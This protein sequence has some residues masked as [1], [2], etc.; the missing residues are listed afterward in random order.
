MAG[1]DILLKL[2]LDD[3]LVIAGIS[4]IKRQIN[5]LTVAMKSDFQR[6]SNAGDWM[7]AYKTKAENLNKQIQLQRKLIADT[8]KSMRGLASQGKANTNEHDKLAVKLTKENAELQK[9]EKSLRATELGYQRAKL[10]IQELAHSED[11]MARHTKSS[12]EALE[13]QGKKAQAARV[14]LNGLMGQHEKLGALVKAEKSYLNALAHEI[15]KDNSEYKKLKAQLQETTAKF[16]ADSAQARKEKAALDELAHSISRNTTEYKEQEIAISQATA[17]HAEAAARIKAIQKQYG[18][19]TEGMAKAYDTFHTGGQKV[20]AAG[21][22]IRNAGYSMIGTTLAVGGAFVKGAQD[23]AELGH[24]YNI[25]GTLI[26]TDAES[27]MNTVKKGSAEWTHAHN[28][29]INATKNVA[30]MQ[31][32]GRNVSLKYGVS[33][34]EVASGYEELVRKGYGAESS[35]KSV[36]AMAEAAMASGDSFGSTL[37][38]V[39]STLESFGLNTEVSA[40]RLHKF[41]MKSN[42]MADKTRAVAN[43]LAYAADITATDFPKL[44]LAM[45]Y[46][47]NASSQL[48]YTIAD[49]ASVLGVLSNNGLEASKAGTGLRQVL[50]SLAA[51]SS[52]AK[53]ILDQLGISLTQFN[54][55]SG[56]Q[57]MRTLP[58][59]FGQLNAKL[60][61]LNPDEKTGILKKIFG[62]TGIAAAGIM[63]DQFEQMGLT[64]DKVNASTK[65]LGKGQ[66]YISKVAKRNMQDAQGQVKIL[67]ATWDDLA[68]SFAR[69]VLPTVI[70]FAKKAKGVVEWFGKLPK[71]LQSSISHLVLMSAT[72]A[73]ILIMT[74]NLVRLFGGGLLGI[75]QMVV[76]ISKLR[77]RVAE[78][79][80][81]S[82]GLSTGKALAKIAGNA[83]KA[84]L[85]VEVA[86]NAMKGA[87]VAAGAGEAAST[88]L[89]AALGGISLATV[90]VVAGVAAVGVGTALLVTHFNKTQA[91]ARK[92][93]KSINQYGINV[94]NYSSKVKES[95]DGIGQASANARVALD[96]LTQGTDIPTEKYDQLKQAIEDLTE[97]VESTAKEKIQQYND[98]LEDPNV[99][100]TIKDDIRRRKGLWEQ[101]QSFL[102][103]HKNKILDIQKRAQAENRALTAEEKA[104]ILKTQREI[105]GVYVDNMNE[106]SKKDKELVKDMLDPSKW[107][108]LAKQNVD[109]LQLMNKYYAKGVANLLKKDIETVE[110]EIKEGGVKAELAWADFFNKNKDALEPIVKNTEAQV[111]KMHDAFNDTG[112]FDA[113]QYREFSNGLKETLKQAGIDYE[114][115]CKFNKIATQEQVDGAQ[116]AFITGS[117]NTTA[118]LKALGLKS[119]KANKQMLNTLKSMKEFNELP[120]DMKA[121]LVHDE[122]TPKITK[123]IEKAG[124]WDNI[125][126]K[127]KEIIANDL[128]SG[129]FDKA[130]QEI[131]E[132]NQAIVDIK[133]IRAQDEATDEFFKAM[134]S[135]QAW[136]DLPPQEKLA[137]AH[138]QAT[139]DFWQAIQTNT[140]WNN[141]P[142]NVKNAIANDIASGKINQAKATLNSWNGHPNKEKNIKAKNATHAGVSAAIGMLNS[143]PLVK[144]VTI[145]AKVLTG[146]F[147]AVRG[148]L[149]FKT[150][151]TTTDEQPVWLGDGRKHEVYMTPQ[152]DFGVTPA[153]DTLYMLPKGSKIFPSISQFMSETGLMIDPRMIPKHATG[154]NVGSFAATD[155]MEQIINQSNKLNNGNVNVTVDT[156]KLEI[157]L[158]ILIELMSEGNNIN[159]NKEFKVPYEST[160]SI[161]ERLSD[162]QQIERRGRL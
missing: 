124:G 109:K 69:N 2:R 81:V 85:G 66:D 41:N 100:E 149:G 110:R 117:K 94:K 72:L 116:K 37:N 26:R 12:A 114:Q 63:T 15:A 121:L 158:D 131:E 82:E 91:E 138:D 156:K 107:D 135:N 97:Y 111:K 78:L 113:A 118:Q 129:D 7:N 123:A 58:D 62:R 56:K 115:F 46:V 120:L 151:G 146:A 71:P 18:G 83:I 50:T 80:A 128:A 147:N 108:N 16:G 47:G 104:E 155:T 153:H 27:T 48:G 84:K 126:P 127:V 61:D 136:N 76:G 90:G 19:M 21:N 54:E 77:T 65:N 161:N 20:V 23:A 93:D 8:E 14:S 40:D 98:I 159:R 11:L 92:A 137:I 96:Q 89:A 130:Q 57:E 112:V 22:A 13:I 29:M 119:T 34:K 55:K 74:G 3:S 88:G 9:L 132:Y 139:A 33:Q 140:G 59:I 5:A 150:G 103:E 44:G 106:L 160:R 73:P 145:G 157:K 79:K 122:A 36:K 4:N 70:E 30:R 10:N 148:W 99:S 143:I 101:E 87:T 24:R 39:S 142:A 141:L 60:K 152:G 51:P 31:E 43:Q 125:N 64:I 53:G 86:T 32:E 154:G 35:L 102:E 105:I 67:K 45:S 52:E 25:V 6:L 144:T 1:D 68:M 42:D 75:G 17:K 162:L 133:S 49:T 28:E 134:E 95:L 38:V